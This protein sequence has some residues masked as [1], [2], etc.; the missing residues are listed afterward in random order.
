MITFYCLSC[1]HKSTN[2]KQRC[3][4]CG[5]TG[6]FTSEEYYGEEMI[7]HLS[8]T[9][10]DYRLEAL[11]K[12][13]EIRYEP[14]IPAIQALMA[15]DKDPVINREAIRTLK[16][17]RAYQNRYQQEQAVLPDMPRQSMTRFDQY[18]GEIKSIDCSKGIKG[19]DHRR[20]RAKSL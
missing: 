18:T 13:R 4:I 20:L 19:M 5:T 2:D 9:F 14:A 7:K 8:H 15:R 6:R 10:R 3:Q 11:R 17:I 16:E 12:I 1:G